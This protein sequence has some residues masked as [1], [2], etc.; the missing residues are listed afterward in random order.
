METREVEAGMLKLLRNV[1]LDPYERAHAEQ[2]VHR[3]AFVLALASGATRTINR[4]G[5]R[6]GHAVLRLWRS[7]KGS[8]QP[9]VH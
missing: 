2:D 9:A 5:R 3:A 4:S 6:L 7:L 1:K 8:G